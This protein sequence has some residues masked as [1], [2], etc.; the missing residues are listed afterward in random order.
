M[1]VH[2]NAN[3]R[4]TIEKKAREARE[5]LLSMLRFTGTCDP[6]A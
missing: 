1:A 4:A 5:H 6:V 3:L 2:R